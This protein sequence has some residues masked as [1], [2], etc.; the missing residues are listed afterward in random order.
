MNTINLVVLND[1]TSNKYI[2]L[3]RKKTFKSISEIKQD[4][5]TEKPVIE[6][7]YYDTDQLRSLVRV[8]EELISMGARI[9]IYENEEMITLKMVKNL[10]EAAKEIAKYREEIDDLMFEDDSAE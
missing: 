9:E 6:C 1:S 2:P 4:I 7:N 10:I 3:L 8:V 5:N